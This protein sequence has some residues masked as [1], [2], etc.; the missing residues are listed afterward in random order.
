[1]V[2][3]YSYDV[4]YIL[5]IDFTGTAFIFK[6]SDGTNSATQTYDLPPG[7]MVYDAYNPFRRLLTRAYGD[8]GGGTITATFDN[9]RTAPLTD[10]W[11]TIAGSV[12]VNGS[13]A[14]AMVLANGQYMFTCP[15]GDDFGKFELDVPLDANGEITVQAFVSGLAP[16]R[17]DADPADLNMDIA[18]QPATPESRSPAVTRVTASDAS[19]PAGWARITGTVTLDDLPLCAM[20]LANGK[21][22]FSCGAN[23]GVYDLTVPLD[24][25]GGITQFVFVSGLKPFK[26][27]FAP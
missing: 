22:K 8:A 3:P 6:I 5:S 7:T 24:G 21:Y 2:Y 15:A 19:T 20:V 23:N 16:F 10:G 13:P 12:A 18:M 4:P 9:V 27:T 14:C 26:Q 1:M 25:N 11:E 17:M